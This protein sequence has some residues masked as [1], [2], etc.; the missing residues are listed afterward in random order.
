VKSF[1]ITVGTFW[2]I[3]WSIG[4]KSHGSFQSNG[5]VGPFDYLMFS[6]CNLM[7]SD[8]SGLTTVS[9]MARAFA[10]TE[11]LFAFGLLVLVVFVVFTS[12]RERHR[13]DLQL[14]VAKFESASSAL[15]ATF[16][17][18]FELTRTAVEGLLIGFAPTIAKHLIAIQHGREYA[19]RLYNENKKKDLPAPL[20]ID[21]PTSTAQESESKSARVPKN[22]SGKQKGRRSPRP[23][24][25]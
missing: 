21:V 23:P 20:I 11:Q 2:I 16:E 7:T 1:L 8:T 5:E 15:S 19:E 13:T 14:V 6:F 12:L 9:Q 4:T 18:D 3:F 24:T 10:C 17:S 22:Q 25:P